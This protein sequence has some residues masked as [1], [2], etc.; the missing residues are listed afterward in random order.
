MP[1]PQA[2][3]AVR[4]SWFG[5]LQPRSSRRS[6]PR[7]PVRRGAAAAFLSIA[8]LGTATTAHGQSA[9]PVMAS[10]AELGISHANAVALERQWDLLEQRTRDRIRC[11]GTRGRC[12][13][14]IEA[15]RVFR[16]TIP[17]DVRAEGASTVSRFLRGKD[18]SHIIPR[19]MGGS[20]LASNGR[21]EPAA[22]NRLRGARPMTPGEIAAADRAAASAGLRA[23]VRTLARRGVRGGAIGAVVVGTLVVLNHGLDL[24]RGRITEAEFWS[25]VTDVVAR[26]VAVGVAVGA[27]VGVASVEFPILAPVLAP[28]VAVAASELLARYGDAMGYAVTE[29][30]QSLWTRVPD[31]GVL[32]RKLIELT[33]PPLFQRN[34]Y[35][36]SFAAPE[37]VLSFIERQFRP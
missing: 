25:L 11:A 30:A 35:F 3:P 10:A 20:D 13:T 12:R 2:H 14:W 23:R 4:S 32:R 27:L 17:P 5:G 8:V 36:P 29:R 7:R 21:W 19:S 37:E 28:V 18:W 31:T 34:S 9:G 22:V 1:I 24:Q 26:D 33:R 6:P 16:S 15:L